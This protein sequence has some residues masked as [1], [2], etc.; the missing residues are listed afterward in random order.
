M[1]FRLKR[2]SMFLATLFTLAFLVSMASPQAALAV[3]KDGQQ[4]VALVNANRSKAG[5][6]ALQYD[7]QLCAQ[8][9]QLLSA[10]QK[11][12]QIPST[13]NLYQVA[14][15]GGYK[16]LGQTVVRGSDVKAM[17]DKQLTCYGNSSV[18]N[19]KYDCV[20]VAMV[21]TTSGKLCVQLLATKGSSKPATPKPT[22]TP[23]P[24]PTPGDGEPN[25]G[26]GSSDASMNQLQQQVVDLVN[27]ERAKQGLKPVVA[28][29]DLT[30]VAQLKAQDMYNK[31]YFSHTSPTYGSPFD[32]MRQQGISY[33]AA[34][35]NIAMGQKTAQQVMTDWM[36]SSGHR[37][38]IL[39]ANYNEIG[40]GVYQS[41]NGYGYIW[42][43][44]FARR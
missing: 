9:A 15:N 44:E 35:E 38:N 43:Q 17:V 3:D 7:S 8:A 28:K 10:Y 19:A 6:P 18:L 42:V 36:N 31:K 1:Q 40:V 25:E 4:M 16:S 22:P 21:N 27:A 34:G 23:T 30:A 26:S 29:Q 37:A 5:L 32:M 39:N 12:G 33:T 14:K 13:A 20:G 24:T 2:V 41:Y 11:T